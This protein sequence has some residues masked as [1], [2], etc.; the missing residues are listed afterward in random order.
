[1]SGIGFASPIPLPKEREQPTRSGERRVRRS[2]GFDIKNILST[3]R[4]VQTFTEAKG[5]ACS[6]WKSGMRD[7]LRKLRPTVFEEI[8]A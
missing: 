3:T 2:L 5:S 7:L 1:M 6:S 8:I 4:N